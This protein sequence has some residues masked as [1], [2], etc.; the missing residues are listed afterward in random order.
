MA[1]RWCPCASLTHL[2][3][4]LL[5]PPLLARVAAEGPRPFLLY[6]ASNWLI[7]QRPR[8][9]PVVSSEAWMEV[10]A[11]LFWFVWVAGRWCPLSLFNPSVGSSS[12]L[13]FLARVAAEGPRP[14][15]LVFWPGWRLKGPDPSYFMA[16]QIVD[17]PLNPKDPDKRQ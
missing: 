15:V 6:G 9:T 12:V 4:L 7:T 11:F 10:L 5:Y 16:P 1:G 13:V 2:L 17:W 8:Q 14:S 3:A